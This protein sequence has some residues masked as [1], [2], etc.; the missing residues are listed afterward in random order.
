MSLY[1]PLWAAHGVDPDVVSTLARM[2]DVPVRV[3]RWLAARG[4]DPDTAAA[5]LDPERRP[6][7][8][9]YAFADMDGVVQRILQVRASGDSVAIVGDYDVD[10][11][12][13]TAILGLALRAVGVKA[14]SVLP[15]RERDGYGLSPV[16]VERAVEAGAR[17]LITVDNGIGAADAVRYALSRGLE[18]IVTDH[19]EPGAEVPQDVPLVHWLR[20]TDP[21]VRELSGAGV[22]WKVATALLD[23]V[24]GTDSEDAELRLYLMGLAAIGALADVMPMRG[25]N[26]RIVRAGLHALRA[27]TAHGWQA[28]CAVAGVVPG[29]CSDEDLVWRIVPRLNAAGRMA[30]PALALSLLTA[31]DAA[32][33]N[34]YATALE[35]LNERRRAE[36]AEAV[37]AALAAIPYPAPS[38]VVVAGPWRL[39]I[40]GIVA[41]KLADA[42]GRPSIVLADDGGE[43]LRGSGRAPAGFPLHAAVKRCAAHLATFGG[44]AGAV[45]LHLERISL[46]VFQ[47]A[48]DEACRELQMS[49]TSGETAALWTDDYLPL[50]DVS[51]TLC[52]WAD[53]FRPYGPDNPPVICFVGPVRVDDVTRF[54]ADGV[55]LKMVVREETVRAELVWFQAGDVP[56]LVPGVTLVAWVT[57]EVNVWRDREEP[58][59][60]V[61]R[62]L[63]VHDVVERDVF[64]DVYRLLRARRRVTVH[65]VCRGVPAAT[66]VHAEM[67][68]ESFVDLGFARRQESA[69]DVN[70]QVT[71]RDLRE[72]GPYHHHLQ[73]C[74]MRALGAG[75]GDDRGARI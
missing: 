25:E 52:Q 65:D 58:R 1:P 17:L 50:R 44:H 36:T 51:L 46:R 16:L 75:R 68:L 30:D 31:Q 12:T 23:A 57:P 2:L 28:L 27:T 48:F 20:A 67:V 56:W 66:P 3:A 38:G 39:G 45:G 61:T 69:Y 10:G 55:H 43:V 73:S 6:F 33:A 41:A 8:S 5:F 72:A 64:T 60:R 4:F 11:V 14:V 26:R 22:A 34:A 37:T 9:P 15:H 71:P 7:S 40:V 35:E 49:V 63:S 53:R 24:G 32:R 21:S 42:L 62:A 59:L 19:H 18:V 47:A 13:A 29:A 70:E 54:G 74:V